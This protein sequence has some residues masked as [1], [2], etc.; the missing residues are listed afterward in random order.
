VIDNDGKENQTMEKRS[1]TKPTLTRLGLLR[2]LTR[3]SF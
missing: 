3:F 2:S 1:Y